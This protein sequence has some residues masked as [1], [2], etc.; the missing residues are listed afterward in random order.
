[1]IVDE[2]IQY[3]QD[4]LYMQRI[5]KHLFQIEKILDDLIANEERIKDMSLMPSSHADIEKIQAEQ[6]VLLH[7]LQEADKALAQAVKEHS[8]EPPFTNKQR[9]AE[10]LHLFQH[11]N[12]TFIERLKAGR[13]LIQFEVQRKHNE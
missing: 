9:I 8:L 11:L 7:G 1:M 3:A 13:H 6:E 12:D 10:K 2:K 5:E 4:E